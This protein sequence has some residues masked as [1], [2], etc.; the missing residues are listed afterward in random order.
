ME[1]TECSTCKAKDSHAG[2][3]RP[4][5]GIR[6]GTTHEGN[7]R[8]HAATSTHACKVAAIGAVCCDVVSLGR[9]MWLKLAVQGLCGESR[10]PTPSAPPELSVTSAS[11]Y[12]HLSPDSKDR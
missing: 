8:E 11:H 3:A 5:R 7:L 2:H 6:V 10:G 9:R 4:S 12:L 1:G